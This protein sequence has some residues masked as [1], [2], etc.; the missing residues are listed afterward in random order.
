MSGTSACKTN[1]N[2]RCCY[3]CG[4]T[5]IPEGCPGPDDDP[6]CKKGF[7]LDD[8]DPGN[9]RATRSKY[10]YGIDFANPVERYVD[11]FSQP[12]LSRFENGAKNPLYQDLKCKSDK[13]CQ[14]P[15][16]PSLVFFAGIVG[17]PWQDIAVDPTNPSLGF[18]DADALA[19]KGTWDMILGDPNASPPV[20]P[21]DP[22]MIVSVDPR[23]KVP[24]PDSAVTAD[25]KNGHDWDTSADLPARSDLQYACNFKLATPRECKGAGEDCDCVQGLKTKNPLCQNPTTGA[26]GTVQYRAKAYPGIREL[27]VLKGI[28]KQGI[29]ASI[30]PANTDDP[31]AA[32]FG[33]RPVMNTVL[34]RLRVKLRGRCLP[35]ALGLGPDGTVPCI[36][37]EAFTPKDGTTCNCSDPAFPGRSLP[38]SDLLT[39]DVTKLGDCICEIQPLAGAARDA[40]ERGD[41]AFGQESGWCYVD[42]LVSRD[43]RQCD[44]VKECPATERRILRYFG[45]APRG[46]V[47]PI[48]QEQAFNPAFSEERGKVCPTP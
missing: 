7:L 21:G 9:L 34:D 18:Q 4:Q 43:P 36:L 14:P 26:Y 16:D 25:L 46:R 40:C 19:S 41:A 38:T 20:P 12:V 48:C 42:P 1:S 22:H 2:D 44:L 15:R 31:D 45:A 6:E 29:V 3:N 47:V 30:C 35:H 11:G 32:D 23:P 33:Y 10:Q 37:M 5:P 39:P 8:D 27:E 28:G 17:V 13:L 24:G